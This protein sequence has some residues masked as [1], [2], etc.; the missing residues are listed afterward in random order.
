MDPVTHT[1]LGAG[2]SAAGLRRATPLATA[3][4]IVAANAPDADI[5]SQAWGPYASLAFR[6]GWTHG[7]GALIVLPLLV[8]GA[9]LAWDRWRRRRRPGTPPARP[10]AVLGLAAVGVWTHPA[11]D[12]LN[13]YGMRWLMPFDSRWSYG[14]VLFIIDPWVWLLLG[15]AL[16]VGHSGGRRARGLW[17]LFAAAL[18][19]PVLA[20]GVAPPAAR[21]VWLAGLAAW[22][23]VRFRGGARM[24]RG[25]SGRVAR[26][27]LAAAGAYVLLMLAQAPLAERIA[28][29]EAGEAG[30][31]GV[32]DVMVSPAPADPFRGRVVVRTEAGYR[33]GSFSWWSTPRTVLD[34]PALR[35]DPGHP[36]A[37]AARTHPEA[38][39]YL[40]WSRFPIFRVRED[41]DGWRVEIRDARYLG[42]GEAGGLTGLTVRLDRD[43]EPR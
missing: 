27:G 32:R 43:L 26:R 17:T 20:S 9:V 35:S 39:R 33:T 15:G 19:V 25:R 22:I 1:F 11:L 3:T 2:L 34:G 36:A 24:A 13:D 31:E 42:R 38:R 37:R 8:T 5:V 18:S 28:A 14:D 30:V 10:R 40:V 23:A 16:F 29:R 4:L 41:P 21:L 12:W 6:R 7:V